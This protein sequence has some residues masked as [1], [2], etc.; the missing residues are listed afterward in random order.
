MQTKPQHIHIQMPDS[1]ILEVSYYC[2]DVKLQEKEKN[3]NTQLIIQLND[4][5]CTLKIEKSV[6][7]QPDILEKIVHNKVII[8]KGHLC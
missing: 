1:K 6:C 7:K 8:S 4:C 3:K 5:I 2:S